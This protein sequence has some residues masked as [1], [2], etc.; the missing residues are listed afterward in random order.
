MIALPMSKDKELLKVFIYQF[1]LKDNLVYLYLF[2]KRSLPI[3][4]NK[5]FG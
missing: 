2:S 3:E 5:F 1:N 4:E